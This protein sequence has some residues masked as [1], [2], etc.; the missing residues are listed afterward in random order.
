MTEFADEIDNI[1]STRTEEGRETITAVMSE[2]FPESTWQPGDQLEGIVVEPVALGYAYNEQRIDAQEASFSLATIA[3][4]PDTADDGLVDLLLS[5]YFI[6]RQEA[7]VSFGSLLIVVDRATIIPVG[8][9]SIYT[10]GGQEYVTTRSWR[11]FPPNT[12]TEDPGNGIL[13]LEERSD[14][15]FQFLLPVESSGTGPETLLSRGT[16][17][18]PDVPFPGQVSVTAASDFGGGLAADTNEDLVERAQQGITPKVLSGF[19]QIEE[20]VATQFPGA[21]ARVVGAN[22]VLMSRDRDNLFQISTG[23]KADIYVR[24][25][26]YPRTETLRITAQMDVADRAARRWRLTYKL[27]GA[28]RVVAVRQIDTA[29]GGGIVPTSET[30]SVSAPESG[31]APKMTDA[32]AAFTAHQLRSVTFID[33]SSITTT[34]VNNAA[35]GEVLTQEWDIDILTQ[36]FIEDVDLYIRDRETRDPALDP[37]VIAA[38]P[39]L[40]SVRIVV[41]GTV[42][43]DDA[44][45]AIVQAIAA[46]DADAETIPASLLYNA[47]QPFV[48]GNVSTAFYSAE[49]IGRDLSRTF[50]TN[51]LELMIPDDPGRGVTAE[52]AMFMIRAEDIT[53]EEV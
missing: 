6:E 29:F 22:N 43:Q 24:T 31:F 48:T 44:K 45:D 21:L 36:P 53:I 11:A 27:P 14:G 19:Q 20:S 7:T 37:L 30:V 47:I 10:A 4:D 40:V 12:R 35:P 28:Y 32:D 18:D 49:I 3:A 25:E 9:G 39:V 52:S 16:V 34:L 41:R 8:N 23:G 50:L 2:A 17:L 26:N 42:E 51:K 13:V 5:N 15:N 1:D 38:L 46:L 33:D